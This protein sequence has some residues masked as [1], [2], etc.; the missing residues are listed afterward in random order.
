[1]TDY[2]LFIAVE[3]PPTLIE[4]LGRVQAQLR[5]ARP[6]RWT[7]PAQM[8]LT[9]QFLGDVPASRVAQIVTALEG[10]VPPQNRPFELT[11]GGLGVFPAPKRP[12]V[13]WVGVGGEVKDLGRLHASVLEATQTV[14]FAAEKRPFKAHLTLGRVDKRARGQDYAQI[15]RVIRDHRED[16]GPIGTFVVDHISLIRSQ[17]KPTGPLYTTLAE[18]SFSQATARI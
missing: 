12:R 6:V 9:L 16:I 14:G 17:L 10:S 5:D 7:K 15:S 13:I 11:A 3:L 4:A 2:R 18:I 1:M 8:H